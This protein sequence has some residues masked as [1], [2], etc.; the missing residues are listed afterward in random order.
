[1]VLEPGQSSPVDELVRSRFAFA[2]PRGLVTRWGAGAEALFDLA[3]EQIVGQPLFQV[4][5]G[6]ADAGWRP[7]LEG[8]QEKCPASLL[9]VSVTRPDGQVFPCQVH[10]V[11]VLLSDGLDFSQFAADLTSGETGSV[12]AFRQRHARVLSLIDAAAREGAHYAEGERLA[13]MIAIFR[14]AIEEPVTPGERIDEALSRAE[15]AE[16]ELEDLRDPLGRVAAEFGQMRAGMD[17]LRDRIDALEASEATAPDLEALAADVEAALG[18]RVEAAAREAIADRIDAAVSARIEA[19][20]PAR[21]EQV[22]AEGVE[23]A[24]ADRVERA[25]GARIE[26]LLPSRVERA[27]AVRIEEALPDRI[28]AALPERV[29][30]AVA[31]RIQ[32]AL[33]G[34]I[35][36]A[37]GGRVEAAVSGY[38]EQTLPES[39]DRALAGRVDELVA[40]RGGDPVPAPL[41]D[42]P[43]LAARIEAAVTR[44]VEQDL[45]RRV[46]EAVG[47]RIEEAVGGRIEPARP[48]AVEE[49]VAGA[50]ERALPA[51]IDDAV[52]RRID[53][54]LPQRI[55]AAVARRLEEALS[56]R[57]GSAAGESDRAEPEAIQ[58]AVAGVLDQALPNRIEELVAG[59]LDEALEAARQAREE[60]EQVSRQLQ[61]GRTAATKPL[62]VG[63]YSRDAEPAAPDR[64]PLPDFDDVATPLAALS[65]EGRFTHLNAAFRELVGY[66]EEE[67]GSARWPSAADP[68]QIASQRE[69]RRALAAGEVDEA[70]VETAYMH[71]EGLLVALVGRM[72]LVRDGVGAPDHLLFSVDVA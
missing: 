66:S 40:H 18:E 56:A 34:R 12:E 3:P 17:A 14:S 37:L 6:G 15:R 36:A 13:G 46:E 4:A 52:S 2:D 49:I 61:A 16:Q 54:A 62:P 51:R 64:P 70:P 10:L 30:E 32:A 42:D 25:L 44:R 67:F 55:E 27:V 60:A 20:L 72:S 7:F 68:E 33:E 58:D 8:D 39:V 29:D 43:G 1:M 38:L 28:A 65:L 69:L 26:E 50:L 45:S 59:R 11:P 21:A 31:R 53:Q 57:T 24:V 5:L 23:R 63:F 22:V 9:E 35:D 41:R 71:R 48:E 19:I 47:E